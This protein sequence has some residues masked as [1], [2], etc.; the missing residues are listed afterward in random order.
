MTA[1]MKS[2][3]EVRY[4]LVAEPVSDMRVTDPIQIVRRSLRGRYSLALTLAV[5]FGAAGAAIGYSATD[6]T[7]QS[8]GFVRIAP[9]TPSVLTNAENALTSTEFAE[10]MAQQE[11]HLASRQVQRQ[12]RMTALSAASRWTVAKRPSLVR[13]W[14][15][16]SEPA[17]AAS[18]SRW[19]GS[20]WLAGTPQTVI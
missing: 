9:S 19:K 14:T 13:T 17:P 6:M 11:G 4:E 1:T 12:V 7:Y 2:R 8:T 10:F 18:Q 20:F 3:D 15:L 5:I 16:M